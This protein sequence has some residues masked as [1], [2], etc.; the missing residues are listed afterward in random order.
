MSSGDSDGLSVTLDSYVMHL[1]PS[2]LRAVAAGMGELATPTEDA[3]Q[4]LVEAV[5]ALPVSD[6]APLWELAVRRYGRAKPLEQ[7][8]GE[9]GMD[10]LRARALLETFERAIAAALPPEG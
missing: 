8:A 3:L 9:I 6:R 10:A 1:R 7:A 4:T 2:E 5:R